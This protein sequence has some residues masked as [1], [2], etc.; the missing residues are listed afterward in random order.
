MILKLANV[1]YVLIAVSMI[2]LILLQ[3]GAGAA[4]GSGFGAGASATVFGARGASNFLSKSTAVLAALFFAI[5]LGMAMYATRG[6]TAGTEDA[7]LGVMGAAVPAASFETP[8]APVD[9]VPAA[10]AT[11]A[12]DS[13]TSDTVIDIPAAPAAE[14]ETDPPADNGD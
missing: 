5:S 2:A 10:A 13:A 12:S 1:F 11:A 9:D 6:S 14:A 4:A 8:V 3:R 7:D